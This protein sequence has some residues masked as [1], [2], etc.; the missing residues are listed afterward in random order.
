MFSQNDFRMTKILF[1]TMTVIVLLMAMMPL[2]FGQLP[3]EV[4]E[5]SIAV[6]YNEIAGSRGWGGL[7]AVPIGNGHIAGITQGGGNV[8]R[9]KY[10]AEYNFPVSVIDFGWCFQGFE[11]GRSWSAVGYRTCD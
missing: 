7:A 9:G 4:D 1:V 6:T 5:T 11:F 8:V 3:A 10:H 2:A